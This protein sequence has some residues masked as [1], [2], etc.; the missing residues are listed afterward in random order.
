[1]ATI[2]IVEDEEVLRVLAES[3]LQE[4]AHQTLSAGT[5]EQAVALLEG[6]SQIDILFTDLSLHG[7]NQAGLTL[8]QRAVELRPALPV[9]YTSG[10][11]LT[12]GMQTMFVEG[13][14]FLPKPYTVDELRAALA[15]KFGV[16]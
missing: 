1:M 11:A 3:I 15:E 6:D 12:D 16:N 10:Q 8:G 5:I 7:D 14:G 13:S 4:H 9:L 2:L